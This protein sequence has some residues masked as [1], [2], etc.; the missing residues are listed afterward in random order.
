M[1]NVMSMDIETCSVVQT[2]GRFMPYAVGWC[3]NANYSVRV[4]ETESELTRGTMLWEAVQT[5]NE[6]AQGEKLFVYAHNGSK[7]DAIAIIHTI[8]ADSGEPVKD[9]LCSNGRFIS[10]TWRNLISAT[11]F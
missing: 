5:W 7:F 3:Y 1:D 9:M 6:L 11:V 10:F 8:L 4:A 2:G